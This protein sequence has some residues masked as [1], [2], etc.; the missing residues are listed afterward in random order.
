MLTFVKN[1]F[2]LGFKK[3]KKSNSTPRTRFEAIALGV[4]LALKQNPNL[5][6]NNINWLDD[7]EF[8]KVTKTNRANN[9]SKVIE[10]IQYVT[11]KLLEAK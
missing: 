4:H 11:T 10:R 6:P 3:S 9:K 7:E 1:Y 2:P 8:K 5:T